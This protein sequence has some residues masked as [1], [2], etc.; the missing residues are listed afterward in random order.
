[1][2]GRY[3]HLLSET[4][5]HDIS[6]SEADEERHLIHGRLRA[7]TEASYFL[8]GLTRAAYSR[9]GNGKLVPAAQ[10]CIKALG[11]LLNFK[12]ATGYSGDGDA[13]ISFMLAHIHA[14][15]SRFKIA[16]HWL[17]AAKEDARRDGAI[18][19]GEACTRPFPQDYNVSRSVWGATVAALE[20]RI[21]SKVAPN[22]ISDL[23]EAEFRAK[24]GRIYVIDRVD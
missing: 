6:N 12:S 17:H 21:N 23:S 22:P 13:E 16:K 19:K 4:R 10:T 9:Y 7:E 20:K 24:D 15:D 3:M 14:C 1:M 11:I 2:D 8:R 18:M 5:K